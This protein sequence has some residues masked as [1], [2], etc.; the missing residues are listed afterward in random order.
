MKR[1]LLPTDFSNNAWNAIAYAMEY[2]ANEECLFFILHTYTPALYRPD[3]ILGGPSFSAIP[4]KGVEIAQAGLEKTVTDLEKKYPNKRHSYKTISAFNV[5][6]DE[7]QEVIQREQIHLIIMGT[8]GATGA[9]EVFMGTHTVHVIRKAR[10][11]VL[12]IPNGYSYKEIHSIVFPTDFT[13]PYE[14]E[15]LQYLIDLTKVKKA[16]LIVLHVKEEYELS[17]EQE[18]NKKA[19]TKFLNSITHTFEEVKGQLMP[20]AIHLYAEKNNSGL[21][22]MMNRKHTFLERLVTQ[23]NVDAI[24]YHTKIP[25]LVLPF[26]TASPLQKPE[27]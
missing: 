4:D 19:L 26:S 9:K 1:I 5:L 2:F 14:L 17:K 27:L 8:Q 7:I 18:E 23:P 25:F 3:Y 16:K 6:T 21:L 22:A 13:T 10:V 11:P 24:G 20:N 15:S 12:V